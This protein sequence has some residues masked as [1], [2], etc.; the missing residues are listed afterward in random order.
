MIT[1]E[2]ASTASTPSQQTQRELVE[3][4]LA[5]SAFVKSKRLSSLLL[6]LCDLALSGRGSEL[7]E[8]RVGEE[9]FGRRRGYDSMID[10]IVRTQASRLRQRLDLYF[11]EEGAN[12]PIRITV[13]RGELRSG[14]RAAL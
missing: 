1:V 7:N 14:L 2:K 3:R 11:S 13:P 10:G 5:S 8:Q 4:V 6:Y 9:V 12:E